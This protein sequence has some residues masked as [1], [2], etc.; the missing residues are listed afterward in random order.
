MATKKATTNAKK[1]T[2][3]AT[4]SSSSKVSNPFGID[5]KN[6]NA[7]GLLKKVEDKYN[8]IFDATS[9]I[10]G[11]SQFGELS[12][13]ITNVESKIKVLKEMQDTNDETIYTLYDQQQVPKR[14]SEILEVLEP[15]GKD[16]AVYNL[17]TGVKKIAASYYQKEQDDTKKF[18]DYAKSVYNLVDTKKTK[19][20]TA[21]IAEIKTKIKNYYAKKAPS[22]LAQAENLE[23]LCRSSYDKVIS[24]YNGASATKLNSEYNAGKKS[25]LTALTNAI[26]N[27]PSSSSKKGGSK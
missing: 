22:R 12:E 1:K 23:S 6:V 3:T 11:N 20:N 18:I 14:V 19:N 25:Y 17:K 21:A 10:N 26:I 4:K 2:T 8:E 13:T 9:H 16:S 27:S 24:I 15:T 7:H 5:Y